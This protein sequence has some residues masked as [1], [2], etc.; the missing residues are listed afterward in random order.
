VSAMTGLAQGAGSSE[1]GSESLLLKIVAAPF[2][3]KSSVR[4]VGCDWGGGGRW[5]SW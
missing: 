1:Q 2:Y 4:E 5:Q 3:T